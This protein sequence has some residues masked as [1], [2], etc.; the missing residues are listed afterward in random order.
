MRS[1]E[2]CCRRSTSNDA[3]DDGIIQI[4]HEPLRKPMA[5]LAVTS[6]APRE[7]EAAA[8]KG[9]AG[10]RWPT[11][12]LEPLPTPPFRVQ[13]LALMWCFGGWIVAALFAF[14]ALVIA[15]A[16]GES[17]AGVLAETA[18]PVYFAIAAATW[19]GWIAVIGVLPAVL[20]SRSGVVPHVPDLM[21]R[22][23]GYS[24]YRAGGLVA[25]TV[26]I[27]CTAWGDATLAVFGLAAWEGNGTWPDD[28]F[29]RGS[30]DANDAP[31]PGR[32][33]GGGDVGDD[34]SSALTWS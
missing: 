24:G 33:R 8:G 26:I 21:L 12:P 11:W 20:V 34:A 1:R 25:A 32:P 13:L 29:P 6:P 15:A 22:F 27:G 3:V 16:R 28:R 10:S 19:A 2:K 5:A 7:E 23:N 30:W 31:E 4:H 14:V 9:G 17:A 18:L